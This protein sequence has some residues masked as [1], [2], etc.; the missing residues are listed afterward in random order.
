V[1]GC[2]VDHALDVQLV[3]LVV[4]CALQ[5]FK[6]KSAPCL[7]TR[8]HSQVQ[9]LGSEP[10]GPQGR[11]QCDPAE[12]RRCP[13]APACGGGAHRHAGGCSPPWF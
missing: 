11:P 5:A 1:S 4:H 7:H 10:A 9:R 2:G 6:F 3:Q 12:P 8:T 13:H